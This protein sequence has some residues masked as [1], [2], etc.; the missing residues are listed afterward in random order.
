[1]PSRIAEDTGKE[2]TDL[3]ESQAEL[4]KLELQTS[5]IWHVIDHESEDGIGGSNADSDSD[6]ED[7][8]SDI[9]GVGD[10]S[11]NEKE[12][13]LIDAVGGHDFM[14]TSTSKPP[15]LASYSTRPNNPH[16]LDLW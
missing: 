5:Q 11:K 15:L 13:G 1:M 7:L 12:S 6:E 4:R 8:D 14:Y 2:C 3:D 16:L 10:L 9:L